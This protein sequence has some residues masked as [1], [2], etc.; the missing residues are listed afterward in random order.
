[1]LTLVII[2]NKCALVDSIQNIQSTLHTWF[3]EHPVI[4]AGVQ[5]GELLA[6]NSALTRFSPGLPG[7]L[8]GIGLPIAIDLA[9]WVL[10]DDYKKK[11]LYLTLSHSLM[12]CASGYV[13]EAFNRKGAH[14][15]GIIFG[16]IFSTATSIIENGRSFSWESVASNFAMVLGAHFVTGSHQSQRTRTIQAQQKIITAEKYLGDQINSL[17]EEIV[18]KRNFSMGYSQEVKALHTM[19]RQLK[20]RITINPDLEDKWGQIL[21]SIEAR[22]NWHVCEINKWAYGKKDPQVCQIL[23]GNALLNDF[24]CYLEKAKKYDASADEF[25]ELAKA[26]GDEEYAQQ[27]RL[28]IL[29]LRKK[30]QKIDK[31]AAMLRSMSPHDGR[32][33][34]TISESVE[35]PL[36]PAQTANITDAIIWE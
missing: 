33:S 36:P 4:E 6:V 20:D 25:Y 16:G 24:E 12:G 17:F 34:I 11:D 18:T 2:V 10:F 26:W 27:A 28:A 21:A 31:H 3:K 35:T 22:G 29:E 9:N 30:I 5:L 32:A 8:P 19:W 1:M 23:R 15:L 14:A 7:V 13:G